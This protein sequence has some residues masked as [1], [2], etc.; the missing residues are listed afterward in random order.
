M[1]LSPAEIEPIEDLYR[2]GLYVQAFRE[3]QKLGA[4]RSWQGPEAMVLAG[5]IAQNTGAPRLGDSI[6][7]RA[8]RRHRGHP[9]VVLFVTHAW[10]RLRGP[11]AAWRFLQ[12][13]GSE[14]PEDVLLR[15]RAHCLRATILASLRDFDR[16]HDWME[17]A[18]ALA[19]GDPWV[20]VDRSVQLQLA[21][22]Y[23]EALASAQH[24]LSL[25]PWYRPAVGSA[26]HLLTLGGRDDEAVALLSAALDHVE[27]AALG[28]GLVNLLIE[29]DRH[30]EALSALDRVEV[31]SPLIEKSWSQWLAG[32]RADSYYFTGDLERARAEALKVESLYHKRLAERLASPDPTARRVRLDV[33]F[34]RQHHETCGPATVSALCRYWSA[35]VDHLTLAEEICY[36][37]T[38]AYKQRVWLEENGW[39]VREFTLTRDAA[40][41]LIERGIPFALSTVEADSAHLQA[42]IGYDRVLETLIVRDPYFHPLTDFL[43]AETL[44]RYRSTGPLAVAI[45]PAPEAKRLD[46]VELP[47]GCLFDRYHEVQKALERHAREEAQTRIEELVAEA[48]SHRITWF[49]RRAA[50]IYDGDT[51]GILRANEELVRLFPESEVFE[52]G[53]LPSLRDLRTRDERLR[54]LEGISARDA[55]NPYFLR[56]L[57]RELLPDARQL[58]E[59][60][61]VLKRSL[62]LQP[63]SAD[64]MHLVGMLHWDRGQRAE[65]LEAHRFAAC[66]EDKNEGNAEAYFTVARHQKETAAALEFLEGRFRRYGRKASGPLRTLFWALEQLDRLDEAFQRLAEA[67][68]WRPDDGDLLLYGAKACARNGSFDR[69]AELLSKARGKSSRAEEVKAAAHIARLAGELARARALLEQVLDLEPSSIAAHRDLA[70]LLAE[71]ENRAAAIAHLER[72]CERF[73]HS[74]V[75]RAELVTWLKPE[76]PAGAE[77]IAVEMVQLDT[78]D[79][80]ARRERAFLLARLG[81]HDEALEEAQAAARIEPLSSFSHST[82][83]QVLEARGEPGAAG[84]AYRE[85][86]RLSAD[87]TFAISC[88]VRSS[89]T[90]DE[91]IGALQFV[92]GELERQ[93]LFGAGVLAFRE[94]AAGILSPAEI[95]ACLREGHAAR[96]DLWYVGTA[97]IHQLLDMGEVGEADEKARWL[98]ER[99]PLSAGSWL[100]L[101]GVHRRRSESAAEAEALEKAL[102]V[103]PSWSSP[104]RKLA[105]IHS[106]ARDFQKA[107][108]VLERAAG[109]DPLDARNHGCLAD[110]LWEL[111][112]KEAA[113]ARVERA[114]RLDPGYDWAWGAFRSWA[115][116]AERPSAPLELAR[117]LTRDRPGDAGVWLRLSEQLEGSGS[118]EA[119]LDAVDRAIA[120]EPL[121]A[122][123]HDRRAVL[124][125]AA[126]RFDDA[127]AACVGPQWNGRPPTTLRGRAA[128]V[129]AERGRLDAAMCGMREVLRDQPAYFWGWQRLAEW[130]E[131]AGDTPGNLAAAEK[132]V[133]LEPAYEV[134]Y[135]Y[136]AHAR[137]QSGDRAGAKA[138][139]RQALRLSDEYKFA[140]I[141]LFNLSI[142]D[143]EFEEASRA[144]DGLGRHAAADERPAFEARLAAA[145]GDLDG[146]L[147]RF[148]GLAQS[149]E[150][151]MAPL[152]YAFGALCDA[153]GE[154]RALAALALA[155]LSENASAHA[156]EL[157]IR[158]SA[159]RSWREAEKN[160]DRLLHRQAGGE[161]AAAAFIQMLVHSRESSRF[162]RLVRR[163][164]PRLRRSDTV[165]GLAG[166][167]FTALGKPRRAVRWFRDW[168]EREGVAAWML[169]NLAD[170]WWVLGRLDQHALVREHALTL[171][172]DRS[173]PYHVLWLAFEAARRNE[174]AKC[175][176]LLGRVAERDLE[177][178]S[179]FLREQ[180][181][182]LLGRGTEAAAVAA[183]KSSKDAFPAFRDHVALRQAHWLTRYLCSGLKTR[184][185][186]VVG[187]QFGLPTWLRGSDH[188]A[189]FT[190]QR[191][192]ARR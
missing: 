148:R 38:P 2:S 154:R 51:P 123:A 139:Y 120:V 107:R 118:A 183:W 167:G 115:E 116:S 53:L 94:E 25:S 135:G 124:L 80:W 85:A 50:A 73:P 111:G 37:G 5:R 182:I 28:A 175:H 134:S 60:G 46:G 8:G 161:A 58:D 92:R 113:L 9:L 96:P 170:A 138:D 70:Q 101:A 162:L 71:T 160:V 109:F 155:C 40:V 128:W 173:T 20:H 125:A 189:L 77:A 35:P 114:L 150:S 31:L 142:E 144:L 145:Q 54:Y 72:A 180:V 112:E 105:E 132:L 191:L 140:A 3:S 16:A 76:D 104:A 74:S 59:A 126:G 49:A 90:L 103:N 177:P 97:L 171:K 86:V 24:A 141:E 61:Q 11:L 100:E 157:W 1:E 190:R 39:L 133:E 44:E 45:L 4:L 185:A 93:T 33:P 10:W 6:H 153:G 187:L 137:Q 179:R 47:D 95:L 79:A 110:V 41:S 29:L 19:P 66:L 184:I 62:R 181:L 89:G 17:R 106:R 129:E 121:S 78:A 156:E 143:R 131:K 169:D 65:A 117:E 98:V 147:L 32:R 64:A 136:R 34:V 15:A 36:D 18:L 158:K 168:R 13:Q 57:A 69:A 91:R 83:G 87:N 130:C 152:A 21:D 102:Q 192:F 43:T 81:R 174:V 108:A 178:Y 52:R 22:E 75:L 186:S 56:E 67:I 172:A 42:V 151:A 82:L 159:E 14:L 164:R 63:L 146:A 176:E 88:L 99:F 122:N 166:F 149:S 165:W 48:P 12:E 84:N 163:H 26:A 23:D 55:V 7:L 30:H 188:W 119:Q 127:I 27:S 68:A